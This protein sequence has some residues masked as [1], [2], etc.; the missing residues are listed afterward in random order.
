MSHIE[1][2]AVAHH[3]EIAAPAITESPARHTIRG[4]DLLICVFF[5]AT[6]RLCVKLQRSEICDHPGFIIG[7]AELQARRQDRSL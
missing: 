1:N 7:V 4:R 6:L 3:E 2:L 5:S